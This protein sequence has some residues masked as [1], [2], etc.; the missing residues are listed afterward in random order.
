MRDENGALSGQNAFMFFEN[1]RGPRVTVSASGGRSH[2][3]GAHG[4]VRV[5]ASIRRTTRPRSCGRTRRITRR[6][7]AGSFYTGEPEQIDAVLQAF[8]AFSQ[9]REEHKPI[10][11]LRRAYR[12]DWTRLDG[13]MTSEYLAA[14]LIRVLRP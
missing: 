10:T 9:V 2:I 7:P 12:D 11:F 1:D 5:R 3:A 8:D 6:P 13:T 14:E 4:V